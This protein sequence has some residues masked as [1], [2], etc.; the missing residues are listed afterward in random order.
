M[1]QIEKLDLPAIDEGDEPIG[2]HSGNPTFASVL[3]VR[4]ARRSLLK[5]GLGLA[6]MGLFTGVSG[7]ALA[8]PPGQAI[9]DAARKAGKGRGAKSL[10]G[11]KA[12]GVSA[13]DTVQ[14]PE[15]YSYQV[16]MPWGEPITGTFPP[17]ALN[18]TG[19][20]QGM[21]VGM[22]HDGMH[23]FPIEGRQPDK[24][25]STDGLLVM[26]HEYIEPRFMHATAQGLLLSSGGYP[27]KADG[28]RDADEVLKELNG[29]G[30]SIA[31][32]NK[33]PNG[34][35]SVRPDHRNRRITGLTHME[36]SGPVRGTDF[37]RTLYSPDG[38]ATR[39]TLNN[40]AHG[41][42]PWNTYMFAEENWAGYFIN[43]NN[44]DRPREQ[45]RYGVRTSGNSRY[46]WELADNGAD[47][48]RR[49]D[50]TPT[51]AGATAD[52]RNE[53]NN[54]GWMV[55]V[56]PFDP[57]STPKKRTALGRFAHEG[58]VFQPAQ[59][60]KPVV[61]YSGDDAQFEYIYKFVSKGKF[62]RGNAGGHLLDEGT[63]YV[64]RFNADGSGEWLPLV[65]GQNGLSMDNGFS[66]QADVLVNTRTAA[67]FVGATPM[68]RPEWGAVDPAN[69]DVYFTLTNNSN[70]GG[71]RGGADAANPRAPNRH[72]HIVR[73]TENG[74]DPEA[75]GFT[76]NIFMFA[77]D[78]SGDSITGGLDPNGEPLTADNILSS[79]DGL[80]ID[81]DSRVWIQ[82]DMS[83]GVQ[84][85]NPIYAMMGNNAMLA[86][87]PHTGEVRRFL[88]G[89]LGQEITGV[90]T[91][92]DQRTMFIN[93]QH[94]GATTSASEW[95]DGT[96][97]GTWPDHTPGVPARSATVVIWKDDGGII[98]S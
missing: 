27:I 65:Y 11:F 74:G 48:Y 93:V 64:A 92:P 10:L 63:L 80:W 25:S 83:E 26:N 86:A 12:V 56:D 14:V 46:G 84:L 40:C 34:E 39:G 43:K 69:R 29:H 49:F 78:A 66:S 55:E 62:N 89:P 17:Y 61:C 21:Q 2:N 18:N 85:T 77:G 58:V 7:H 45:T 41:V 37:V 13:L 32:I 9:A 30:V 87:D 15:G 60:G 94:P 42:T 96:P 23:F 75:T 73:W 98:G 28:S 88:T 51:A 54:F 79:P 5:G 47:E 31:R 44:S 52:Y 90:I 8:G 22:H 95:R 70:R 24:G 57:N 20:D 82:M 68:D 36:L 3:E 91:T 76:W 38:T 19:T 59:P 1:K 35:W 67:D 81:A 4:M 50:V 53:A 97:R 72:G 33:G 6:M 71:N 16:L